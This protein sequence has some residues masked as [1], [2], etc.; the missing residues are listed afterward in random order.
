MSLKLWM[1]AILAGA[2]AGGLTGL[3]GRDFLDGLVF[4]STTAATVSLL[5]EQLYSGEDD[6]LEPGLIAAGP[7]SGLSGGIV[8]A[9][10]TNAGI[11][12]AVLGAGIGFYAGLLLPMLLSQT[13]DL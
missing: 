1:S 13:D 11:L 10:A 2:F 6:R 7:Y 5:G 8:S 12:G 9:M 3:I 4:G